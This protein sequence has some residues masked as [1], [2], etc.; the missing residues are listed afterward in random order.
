[1]RK[2]VEQMGGRFLF[3]TRLEELLLQP[4]VPHGP[5][6]FHDTDSQAANGREMSLPY[7]PHAKVGAWAEEEEEEGEGEGEGEG[8]WRQQKVV[9]V[10]L[11]GVAADTMFGALVSEAEE[12]AGAAEGIV[13]PQAQQP[14]ALN[15]NSHEC[16]TVTLPASLCVLGRP[17]RTSDK[18]I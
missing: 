5:H 11:R 1:M 2:Q 16:A 7:A 3:H 13:G 4:E 10:R 8:G 6:E 9:G 17:S 15:V 14:A 18:V 12:A